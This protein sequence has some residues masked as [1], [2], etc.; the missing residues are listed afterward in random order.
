MPLVCVEGGSVDWA[1]EGGLA[2]ASSVWIDECISV[3]SCGDKISKHSASSR[4]YEGF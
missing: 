4:N 3:F 2:T 1:N